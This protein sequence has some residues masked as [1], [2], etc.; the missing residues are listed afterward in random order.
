[1]LYIYHREPRTKVLGP[2]ERY[3]IW[4][5]GCKKRCPGC[6]NPDG[7]LEGQNGY[8]IST[9][10]VLNELK[11]EQ[12]LM[13]ITISGGEPFLQ[14]HGLAELVKSIKENTQL[15]IMLYSGYTLAELRA[16]H[17]NDIDFVLE[18]SDI[19][20]DGEYIEELNNNTIYRGSDNQEIHFLSSR[21][22]KFKD[23]IYKTHNRDLEF[24]SRNGELFMIGIPEKGFE[25]QFKRA[26]FERSN[27]FKEE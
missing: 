24:I 12:G 5:Q 20:V 3:V 19:L 8:W 23:I 18:H 15:D 6:I 16:K 9:E 13:G 25:A 7:Q 1:M 21:Y 17:D 2:G 27:H 11:N 14:A 4:V 22:G 26:I 10:K